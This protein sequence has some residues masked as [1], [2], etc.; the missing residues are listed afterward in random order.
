VAD[1]P[2]LDTPNAASTSE[3]CVSAGT[4]LHVLDDG[5][6]Y[7]CLGY[8]DQYVCVRSYAFREGFVQASRLTAPASPDQRAPVVDKVLPFGECAWLYGLHDPYD[9]DLFAYTGKTGWVL[10]TE[11]VV[12]GAGNTGYEDWARNHYYGVIARLN[13]DYG[14]TGTI[15]TPDQYDTF[16]AQCAQWVRNSRGCHIWVIGNEMNNPR[17]WPHGQPIQPE[18]YADCF[19]RARA[20]IKSV[21]P[22]AMVVPGAVDPY[23]G[24][25]MS[26]LEWLTRMFNH[27]ADLDGIALHCYTQGYEPPLVTDLTRFDDD[28]LRWQYYHLRCYTTFMDVIPPHWRAKPVYITETDPH[29]TSPWAGGQNGWVQAAYAEINRWNQQPHAQQIQAL[30]LYRWSRDDIY[31]IS[32][33]PGV[34]NDIRATIAN[35]DVRWRR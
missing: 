26:C 19:N 8:P 24:P 4:P 33:K 31:S 23:Q 2:L 14:G 10:F 9:R 13:N 35:S 16:A 30:V 7:K 27:I 18:Q 28:P 20:A 1:A 15:P 34:Q 22:E 29:G 17:E 5:E 32:D 21:Q 25:Q 6:W 3:W 12:S 11:R